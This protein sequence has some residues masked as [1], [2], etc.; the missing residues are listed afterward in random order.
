[1]D[2]SFPVGIPMPLTWV[3]GFVSRMS[4]CEPRVGP[5]HRKFD[6]NK[7]EASGPLCLKA[8]G[9]NYS[10]VTKGALHLYYII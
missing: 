8:E 5:S 2:G 9:N 7:T 1:M 10:V 3:V 6:S 4:L